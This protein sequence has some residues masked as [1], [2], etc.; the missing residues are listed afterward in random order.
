MPSL[1]DFKAYTPQFIGRPVNRIAETMKNVAT[2][3]QQIVDT[4]NAIDIALSNEQVSEADMGIVNDAKAKLKE[5]IGNIATS[6]DYY[7]AKPRLNK[8]IKDTYLANPELRRANEE[9][10]KQK[11]YETQLQSRIGKEGFTKDDYEKARAISLEGYAGGVR[12]GKSFVPFIPADKVDLNKLV[13]EYGKGYMPEIMA[14]SGWERG[15]GENTG[16]IVTSAN[17]NSKSYTRTNKKWS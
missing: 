11:Q 17:K 14:R 8:A 6:K 2:E 15:T 5:E 1:L 4:A 13:D 9:Y 16:Y 12:E 10:A 3:N 7:M